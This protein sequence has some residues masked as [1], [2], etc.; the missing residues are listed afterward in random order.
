M[1][2][3]WVAFLLTF[4][5]SYGSYAQKFGFIDVDFILKKMPEYQ[6]AQQEINAAASKWEEEVYLRMQAVEDMK[7]KYQA[8]E[9]LLTD[10][11]KQERLAKINE[12]DKEA[13]E[14]NKKI[15]GYE[16]MFYAK[17]QEIMK[18]VM[19]KLYKAIERV[20]RK[21][22]IQFLFSNSEG[23][24]IVFAEP[25]HDYTEAVLEELGLNEENKEG[26][27]TNSQKNN[28]GTNNSIMNKN[29]KSIYK[30]GEDQK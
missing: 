22:R 28:I 18:P 9:I 6:L 29:V 15:F 10:E 30:Q 7:R 4:L 3:K 24:T 16:G 13:K 27:N 5:G 12:K 14:L 23:L 20:A 1:I 8:E 26:G 17:K 25:R 2:Q 21:K 11:M 19:E